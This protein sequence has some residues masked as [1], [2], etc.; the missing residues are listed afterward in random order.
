MNEEIKECNW[1]KD[2]IIELA[3]KV[4]EV[5]EFN[6]IEQSDFSEVVKIFGGSV[7]G[8]LTKMGS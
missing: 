5:A 7:M 1:S 4:A 2:K 6:P 3:E 8:K